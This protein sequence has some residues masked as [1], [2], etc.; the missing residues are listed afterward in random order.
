MLKQLIIVWMKS[1]KAINKLDSEIKSGHYYVTL[2]WNGP[3]FEM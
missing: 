3:K 1:I 2:D